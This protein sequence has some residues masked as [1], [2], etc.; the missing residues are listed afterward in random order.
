MITE[1]KTPQ[2]FY[3][4]FNDIMF[5]LIILLGIMNII[6]M[7]YLPVL[8]RTHDYREFGIP[9]LDPVCNSLS[10]FFSVWFFE[11][12]LENRKKR[13]LVFVLI[14]LIL[15]ILIFRR[16][17]IVWIFTASAFLWLFYKQK[18]RII[19]LLALLITLPVL[20]YS[21]GLYGN[22]R[23][24]L[25]EAYIL[26]DLGASDAFKSLGI[27]HNHYVTYL[28]IS[29]PMANLQRNIDEGKGLLNKS[30]FKSFF[31][32]SLLPESITLRLGNIFKLIR[33]EP[34]LIMSDL[35]VGTFFMVSFCTLGWLGM[36]GMIL[37][38]LIFI[39]GCIFLIQKFNT[40]RITTLCILCTTATLLIFSNFLNRLDV[41]MM[42][43]VYPILFH[44]IINRIS[45]VRVKTLNLEP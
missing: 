7:G 37:F 33:S 27:S 10:I 23:S 42:I 4:R 31:F 38:L 44:Y 6:L 3:F 40:F 16:S 14:I 30:D 11:S 24:N 41:I 32:F 39:F 22:T 18:I 13:F 15:Q 34:S 2:P 8:D 35:I 1:F 9:V 17:T 5:G 29:S 28:Y 21:F 20:S 12:F 26:E 36:S 25:S 43:F 45:V 19:I